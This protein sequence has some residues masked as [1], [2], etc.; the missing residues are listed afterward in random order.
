[1]R[2]SIIGQSSSGKTTLAKKISE[3]LS[4]P[5]IHLDRFWFEAGGLDI[6]KGSSLE[7][8]ER[9]R[10]Y[11]RDNTLK[12]IAP[13]SWVS[14]GFYSRE[15]SEIA[16]KANVVIFLDTPLWRRLLNHAVRVFKPEE[17]HSEL[18]SWNE[19]TFFF[20]IIRRHFAFRP[21]FQEFLPKYKHKIV[22]LRSRK[23][24]KNYVQTL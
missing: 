11:I 3:R 4:I 14:D 20:E 5:H 6:T 21:K 8:K 13:E 10:K 19:F 17:R 18:S 9:I 1:M 2:I 24:I 7:E 23:E 12:A 15:Q 22:T 16:N